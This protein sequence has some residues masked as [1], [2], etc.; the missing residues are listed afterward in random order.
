MDQ[1]LTDEVGGQLAILGAEPSDSLQVVTMDGALSAARQVALVQADGYLDLSAPGL[2]ASAQ[3]LPPY[4]R[5]WPTTSNG[6]LDGLQLA[7]LRTLPTDSLLYAVTGHD[8]GGLAATIPYNSATD[9]HEIEVAFI[10][11]TL[12]GHARVQGSHAGK[13]LELNVDYR[14]QTVRNNHDN[15][16]FANDGNLKLYLPAGSLGRNRASFLM[17]SP[18][19]LPGPLPQGL[20][21]V[22][23]AYEITASGNLVQ[24]AKPGIL[25]I[26]YDTVASAAFEED[27]LTLYRWNF[28]SATWQKLPSQRNAEAQPNPAAS[29]LVRP[30][31]QALC[32]G[33]PVGG[34]VIHL[35]IIRKN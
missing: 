29:S 26:R 4:L 14:L 22:G 7:L 11:A 20:D 17:A 25:T 34:S 21:I 33:G 12:A 32:G 6:E 18:W 8:G 28:S 2:G 13:L 10:P 3:K 5:L 30:G 24:L 19:G 27:S 9:R 31:S 23:E 1:G 15:D 16:L 35:P